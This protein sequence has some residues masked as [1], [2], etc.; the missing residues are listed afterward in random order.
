MK[1]LPFKIA[2]PVNESFW[3]QNDHLPHL[4][5]ILHQ[6]DE[7]Q[8]TLIQESTGNA[9]AGNRI[10]EFSPGD[11]FVFGGK[12]PHA[13][14]NDAVYYDPANYLQA[15]ALSVYFE[16]NV[17]GASFWALPETKELQDL[18]HR[19]EQGIFFPAK[20]NRA[21]AAKIEELATATATD[22]LILLL[23]VLKQLTTTEHFEILST[24]G[25]YNN[26]NET[27]EMRLDAIYRFTLKEYYRPI[28]LQEIADVAH[29]TTNSFCR[30][31]KTRTR[32]SYLDF[33]TEFRIGQA[34]KLL[35]QEEFGIAD[36][37][38]QVGFGNLSNFNRKFKQLNDCT[39]KEYRNK[40]RLTSSI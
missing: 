4:Y 22:R 37:A 20:A 14:R 36:I 40:L 11:I 10:C 33:L 34:C 29:M 9:I 26:L 15:R 30:Y 32:K 39:P 5:D 2:K 38:V 1:I 21:I 3:I 23:T 6:H 31:F 35:Q 13:F 24:G 7:F 12:L 27:D 16:W 25:A 28:S 19:A 8:I 18:V 17:L